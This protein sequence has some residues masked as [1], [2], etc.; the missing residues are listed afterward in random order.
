MEEVFGAVLKYLSDQGLSELQAKRLSQA[1]FVPVANATHLA[2]PEKLFGR[3]H[4]NLSP[5]AFEVP[6]A[7][8]P[9][10]QVR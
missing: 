4:V 8:I 2:R 9:Y 10:M 6:A 5:F 3:L 1:A 7:F